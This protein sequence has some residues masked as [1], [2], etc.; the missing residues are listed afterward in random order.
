V[1]S[2]LSHWP[3]LLVLCVRADNLTTRT[4]R[5]TS[6][7]CFSSE[8][9]LPLFHHRLIMSCAQLYI[10]LFFFPSADGSFRVH[11][12][13]RIPW[14]NGFSVLGRVCLCLQSIRASDSNRTPKRLHKRECRTSLF[15]Q[16]KKSSFSACTVQ[17]NMSCRVSR[18]C[19]IDLPLFVIRSHGC[20]C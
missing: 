17:W 4:D 20:T 7:L 8:R 14:P 16:Q 1:K 6:L 15:S 2:F 18:Q 9:E 10:T 19:P 11:G 13:F 12:S 5:Q 3:A